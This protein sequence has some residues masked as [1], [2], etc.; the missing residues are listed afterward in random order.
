[1]DE[2]DYSKPLEGQKVKP[3]SEHWRKHTLSSMDASGKVTLEYRPVIDATLDEKVCPSVPP[4]IR[5]Y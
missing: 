4:T 2:F 3:L 1:M 5:S